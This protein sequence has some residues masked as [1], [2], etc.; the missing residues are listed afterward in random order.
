MFKSNLFLLLLISVTVSCHKNF[1]PST[2]D[3]DSPVSASLDV[4]YGD[5]NRKEYYEESNLFIK[6]LS[7]STAAVF[8]LSEVED[9]GSYLASTR[10]T[11]GTEFGL[12]SSEKFYEQ[13]LGPRCS[14][15]L[16]GK[17][18]ILT[19]S[20][21][22]NSE[23]QCREDLLFNFDFLFETALYEDSHFSKENS[24]RCIKVVYRKDDTDMVLVKLDRE[25]KNIVPISRFTRS[26]KINEG[27]K[28]LMTGFPSGLPL[29]ISDGAKVLK[30]FNNVF[31]T[32]L[33][34]FGGNSGSPVFTEDT[35]ELVG[36]L[37]NGELDFEDNGTCLVSKKCNE[38][39]CSGENITYI[40]NIKN[41]IKEYNGVATEPNDPVVSRPI[42][43]SSFL[44]LEIP[45]GNYEGAYSSIKVN[46]VYPNRKV[47]IGIRLNHE[48]IGDLK[49]V[50]HPPNGKSYTLMNLEAVS[51]TEYMGV[52]GF[53]LV[54]VDS[55]KE[56]STGVR[57]GV[58]KL[59]VIDLKYG[60]RGIL[61]NWRVIFD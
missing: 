16:V 10:G 39:Q 1:E 17:D 51:K 52:F 50:L 18:L 22:V 48:W 37:S 61:E 34:S 4:I 20:H 43:Y 14:G 24:Y 35:G 32:D 56:M 12:C 36:I 31:V 41:V 44:P 15:V 46:K 3:F 45:D 29:K 59:Q 47:M 13:K 6:F 55:L 54:P 58:W 40:G 23:K 49:I 53:D 7:R 27:T 38:G 8:N 25:V 11:F 42:I 9:K 5:D 19:A 26:S 33:D 57:A 28:V 21:C 2:S 30:K 60:D